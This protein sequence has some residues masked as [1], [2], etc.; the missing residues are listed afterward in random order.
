MLEK[1]LRQAVNDEATDIFD[2]ITLMKTTFNIGASDAAEII[3][4]R[5]NVEKLKA[6]TAQPQEQ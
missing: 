5:N 2:E 1:F 3:I 6:E 4:E